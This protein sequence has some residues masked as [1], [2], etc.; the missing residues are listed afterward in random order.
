MSDPS[1]KDPYKV[2]P[3][4][5][6]RQ[7]TWFFAEPEFRAGIRIRQHWELQAGISALILVTSE[8]PQWNAEQPIYA[9]SDGRAE[10]V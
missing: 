7:T 2:G 9:A 6:S 4:S 8:L 5:T 3:V 10:S 1:V